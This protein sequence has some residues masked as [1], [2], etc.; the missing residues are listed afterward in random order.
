[1]KI[2][3]EHAEGERVGTGQYVK[4]RLLFCRVTRERG[5]IVRGHAQMA[6]FVETNLT[7]AALTG[8]DQAAMTAGITFQRAGFQ[9]FRD[10]R[11]AFSGHRIEDV[12][13]WRACTAY[14]HCSDAVYILME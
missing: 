10:F 2:A 4:E 9:V 8:L 14:W 6:A 3:A 11:R 1:M 12:C 13:K 7:N 5:N